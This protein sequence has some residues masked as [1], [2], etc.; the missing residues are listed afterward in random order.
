LNSNKAPW[1][2]F[3]VTHIDPPWDSTMDRAS[4]KSHPHSIGLRRKE[5]LKN[6]FGG[7]GRYPVARVLDGDM[8]VSGRSRAR[9]DDG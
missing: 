3:A 1:S 5:R 7:L 9:H 4:R 6:M 8:H 2:W